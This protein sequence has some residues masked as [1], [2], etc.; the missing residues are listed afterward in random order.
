MSYANLNLEKR[1]KSKS[2]RNWL[3]LSLMSVLLASSVLLHGQQ[4]WD[5]L[6]W[7][8]DLILNA[9][10]LSDGTNMYDPMSSAVSH[11][12]AL[13]LG[14]LK[15]SGGISLPHAERFSFANSFTME[16]LYSPVVDSTGTCNGTF[17]QFSDGAANWSVKIAAN[18]ITVEA[19]GEALSANA[20]TEFTVSPE[21]VKWVHVAL[22]WERTEEVVIGE[23]E[24]AIVIPGE[25][26]LCLLLNGDEVDSLT[27]DVLPDLALGQ[28]A[29]LAD[30]FEQGFLDEFR[31]WSAARD[32]T[33]IKAYRFRHIMPGAA[34]LVAN[35]RFD[36][37]GVSIEDFAK[38]PNFNRAAK[39]HEKILDP[40][41]PDA[42]RTDLETELTA[43]F[44]YRLMAADSNVKCANMYTTT[45]DTYPQTVSV[46]AANVTIF[47]RGHALWVT[48]QNVA[49]PEQAAYYNDG[50]DT[51]EDGVADDGFPELDSTMIFAIVR[52]PNT[53]VLSTQVKDGDFMVYDWKGNSMWIL[54]KD[55]AVAPASRNSVDNNELTLTKK[56]LANRVSNPESN[57]TTG[58]DEDSDGV[59]DDTAIAYP[60]KEAVEEDYVDT[61]GDMLPD[62]WEMAFFGDLE[63]AGFGDVYGFTDTDGD[64]LNDYYEWLA[65][66]DPTK[67]ITGLPG[68]GTL[69][70]AEFD[71][72]GDGLSNLDEQKLGSPDGST[73]GTNP[74]LVDTDDDGI[75]DYV[76][77][78]G[79]LSVPGDEPKSGPLD[80]LGPSVWRA[81]RAGGTAND[82]LVIPEFDRV[83]GH[84]DADAPALTKSWTIEAWF[85]LAKVQD[86]GDVSRT[87]S[88][89]RRVALDS[90]G[91]E[92]YYFDMGLIDGKPYVRTTM[93]GSWEYEEGLTTNI[94][95]VI[96][97]DGIK[98]LDNI[99]LHYAA[100]WN[101][102]TKA[103]NLYINGTFAGSLYSQGAPIVDGGASNP[104]FVTEILG[105]RD[106]S[107][108]TGYIDEVRVWCDTPDGRKGTRLPKQIREWMSKALPLNTGFAA[109]TDFANL[110]AALY[111]FDDGGTYA[112]D[113]SY[114]IVVEIINKWRHSLQT[115]DGEKADLSA[116]M[117]STWNAFVDSTGIDDTFGFFW[118][119]TNV[120]ERAINMS[121]SGTAEFD[122]IP[123]GWQQLYWGPTA[124]GA[125]DLDQ[126]F[127]FSATPIWNPDH[128]LYDVPRQFPNENSDF[129]D[130]LT[131]GTIWNGQ[132]HSTNRW[133]D[134]FVYITDIFIDDISAINSVDLTYLVGGFAEAANDVT[135]WNAIQVFVNAERVP[136]GN[137]HTLPGGTL[138]HYPSPH[139]SDSSTSN[140]IQGTFSIGSRF[141]N[142]RNRI[143]IWANHSN[144]NLTCTASHPYGHTYTFG[145]RI[146]IN[147]RTPDN[148]T[149]HVKWFY[150]QAPSSSNGGVPD[151]LYLAQEDV[152]HAHAVEEDGTLKRYFWFE[153]YY[154]LA[155]WAYDQDPD[156]DG[157]TNW[158]EY[159]ANTNPLNPDVDGDGMLDGEHDYD[160][161]G[162]NN[163]L[164][165]ALNTFIN[166]KD[167]DDDGVDDY[168]EFINGSDPLDSL[169]V[170]NRSNLSL[171]ADGTYVL[172]VPEV[173]DRE[174]N[175]ELRNWTLEA[176]VKP[177]SATGRPFTIVNPG[178]EDELIVID[179]DADGKRQ[180]IMART[181]GR[182]N[183]I[184]ATN[185]EMGLTE[186]GLPYAG[187]SVVKD[188]PNGDGTKI[189]ANIHATMTAT[190]GHVPWEDGVWHHLAAVFTAPN[191]VGE[192]GSIIIYVDGKQ[193][194]ARHNIADKPATT[195]RGIGGITIA[196]PLPQEG[197]VMGNP[198]AP[199]GGAFVGLIDNVAIWNVPRTARQV[200][201]T[202]LSGL[203]S[204]L[205]T[206][207]FTFNCLKVATPYVRSDATLMHAFLF[208]DG[209]KT[210][211][212]YAW[213]RD[214][215]NGFA[216]AISAPLGKFTVYELQVE[217]D[218]NGD[219]VY[220]VDDQGNFVY[221]ANNE[222]VV[223]MVPFDP[224][225]NILVKDDTRSD[226]DNLDTDGDG[227]PD[228]WEIKYFGTLAWGAEDDPD[229]DGLNNLYEYLAGKDPTKPETIT[230]KP[231]GEEDPDGDGLTNLMEQFWGTHPKKR[232]SDDDGIN[233]YD[234]IHGFFDVTAFMT[235]PNYSMAHIDLNVLDT[236]IDGGHYKITPQRSLKM[237]VL[238]EAMGNNWMGI[239]L[240]V[241]DRF[242]NVPNTATFEMWLYIDSAELEEGSSVRL[243]SAMAA[244]TITALGLGYDVKDGGAYL[245]GCFDAVDT[246]NGVNGKYGTKEIKVGGKDA[247][248]SKLTTD[249]WN[250]V[251][252]TWDTTLG[253]LAVIIDG[254]VELAMTKNHRPYIKSNTTIEVYLGGDGMDNAKSLKSGL[255][256]EVRV[257]RSTKTAGELRAANGA[258]IMNIFHPD[259]LAYYRFDD[260]GLNI[261]DFTVPYPARNADTY[262]LK[263]KDYK[264]TD[265][266]SESNIGVDADGK[267]VA[268]DWYEIDEADGTSDWVVCTG[269]KILRGLD[270]GDGD[271]LPDWWEA[272][273]NRY[274]KSDAYSMTADGDDDNFDGINGDYNQNVAGGANT[275]GDD[276][277]SN[278]YEYYCRTSPYSRDSDGNGVLDG[279]EDFDGDGLSNREEMRY[280]SDPRLIDTDD[281]EFTD[282]EEIDANTSPSHPCSNVKLDKRASLDIAA[283]VATA[284]DEYGVELYD[285]PR[286]SMGNDEWTVET[287]FQMGTDM[288]GDIFVFES[289][290]SDCYGLSI[291]EG[292]PV[293]KIYKQNVAEPTVKVGGKA[294]PDAVQ[295]PQL[296]QGKWY[297]LALV[298]TPTKHSF[299]LYLDGI[300]MIAVQTQ[301]EADI[302]A[303]KAYLAKN[304][305][306]GFID[307]F[308]V[309]K[310]ARSKK[311]LNRW[312]YDI[313]P[314]HNTIDK[315]FSNANQLASQL[316]PSPYSCS[317]VPAWNVANVYEYADLLVTYYRFDDGGIRAEDF[318]KMGREYSIDILGAFTSDEYAPVIGI[319]D[320][321]SDQIP[322]WWVELHGLDNW[323]KMS[324]FRSSY[325]RNSVIASAGDYLQVVANNT[326]MPTMGNYNTTYNGWETTGWNVGSL[327]RIYTQN[328]TAYDGP[329][330]CAQAGHI[331]RDFTIFGSLGNAAYRTANYDYESSKSIVTYPSGMYVQLWKY[332]VLDRKPMEAPFTLNLWNGTVLSMQVNGRAVAIT[333]AGVVDIAEYLEKGRNQIFL[334][335]QDTGGATSTLSATPPGYYIVS[336]SSATTI[337]RWAVQTVSVPRA[338]MKA[339]FA[340][341][342][343]GKEVIVNGDEYK[344]DPRAVWHGR[345]GTLASYLNQPD[346]AAK[347][348]GYQGYGLD[349]D[350]DGDGLSNLVEYLVNTNP[351]D[352]DSNNNGISDADEDF[353]GDGVKN[354]DEDLIGT[355]PTMVDTDDDGRMDNEEVSLG[356]DPADGNSPGTNGAVRFMGNAGEYLLFPN[357][358]RFA[359]STYTLEFWIRP[360][361]VGAEQTILERAVGQ[362][363]T[364]ASAKKLVNY[365]V[366]LDVEGKVAMYYTDNSGDEFALAS[367][368]PLPASE[369]THVAISFDG[370]KR[371]I[372]LYID[373]VLNR[374]SH[375]RVSQLIE[376]PGFTSVKA[377]EGFN[378][379]LDD[380][381]FWNVVRTGDEIYAGR[382][383]ALT[384]YEE[385]L[386]AY[387]RFDDF[388][389]KGGVILG[390]TAQ[391]SASAYYGDWK[392]GWRNAARF[393]RTSAGTYPSFNDDDSEDPPIIADDTLDTDGDGMP[394]EWEKL[395]GL[396]P[397]DPTDAWNDDDGD[398]LVN[399]YEYLSNTN[400]TL[401]MTNSI[402]MDGDLDY[403]MDGL[404]NLAEQFAGSL[405]ND[406][407]TDDD[408]YSDGF[409]AGTDPFYVEG[410]PVHGLYDY[411]VSPVSS[412]SQPEQ[413]PNHASLEDNDP[414]TS[415]PEKA[416]RLKK[417]AKVFRM[418]GTNRVKVKDNALQSGNVLTIQFWFRVNKTNT[419][420]NDIDKT[421]SGV[422]R[423][424]PVG[425]FEPVTFMRRTN[426]G[427]NQV[428]N[429]KFT[430]DGEAIRFFISRKDGGTFLVPAVYAPKFG[431]QTGEES[432]YLITAVID[433][434]PEGESQSYRIIGMKCTLDKLTGD[435][436][437]DTNN[438]QTASSNRSAILSKGTNAYE[439]GEFII[440]NLEGENWPERLI[441]DVDTVSFWS[442]AKEASAITTMITSKFDMSSEFGRNLVSQFIFDDGGKT[443]EDIKQP[444]DWWNDWQHAGV[445]S[446]T[447]QPG[448]DK[449]QPDTI[450]PETI[451][452]EPGLTVGRG[453]IFDSS[454]FLFNN[455]TDGDGLPDDWEIYFFGTLD[456][457]PD[458]DFDGD[459]LTNKQEYELSA[460]FR[461]PSLGNDP[462][463]DVPYAW[464]DPTSKDSDGDGLPDGWENTYRGACNPLNYGDSEIDFDG[465]GLKN[466][467][468]YFY[469]TNPENEDTDGD[470]LPDGWEVTYTRYESI[471]DRIVSTTEPTLDP[472]DPTGDY[473]RDGDPDNDGRTNEEEF[474]A[475]SNPLQ[476]DVATA[477]TDND[478]LLNGDEQRP[479]INT[480]PYL[481]DTDDDE[482]DDFLELNSGTKGFDS[483][484]KPSRAGAP[485]F[486]YKGNLVGQIDAQ[487]GTMTVPNADDPNRVGFSTWTVEARF[488]VMEIDCGDTTT[489]KWTDEDYD[490]YLVRRSF[491][492]TMYQADEMAE[493]AQAWN[494]A[495]GYRVKASDA[496]QVTK[497]LYPFISFKSKSGKERFI[498]SDVGVDI[499]INTTDI[500]VPGT[501]ALY[502]RGLTKWHFLT[503]V[504]DSIN[505]K[506][507]MYLDGEEHETKTY[508]NIVKVEDQ[509]PIDATK[510]GSGFN[511]YLKLGENFGNSTKMTEEQRKADPSYLLI[512]EVRV[513]GVKP[514][515]VA[516]HSSALGYMT[517]FFRNSTEIADGHKRPITPTWGIYDTCLDDRFN[518]TYDGGGLVGTNTH[519]FC[520]DEHVSDSEWTTKPGTQGIW[521]VVS[522]HDQNANGHWD[523]GEDVWRDRTVAEAINEDALLEDFDITLYEVE[524]E[525]Q[526]MVNV[527]NP[528]IDLR[529]SYGSDGWV[530]GE[531][532][533]RTTQT[534][535]ANGTV[536]TTNVNVTAEQSAI[537]RTMEVFYV[538]K[539][540]NG[541]LDR[542]DNFWLEF[543]TDDVDNWY[544]PAV[545]GWA[546]RQG[547]ALYLRF[548]DGGGSIE[549]YARRSD[550]RSS[551]AWKH[552]IRPTGVFGVFPPNAYTAIGGKEYGFYAYVTEPLSDTDDFRWVTNA[553]VAPKSPGVVIETL[554]N[555]ED[556]DQDGSP[557]VAY[558][559]AI[560]N[561]VDDYDVLTAV[562]K[563]P[564]SDPEGGEITYRYFW[565][566]ENGY[567]KDQL[568]YEDGKLKTS[569]TDDEELPDGLLITSG[570]ELDLY[571][572]RSLIK[573]GDVV[574]LA[575]LAT[576]ETGM[577]SEIVLIDV[578]IEAR[579]NK[580][581]APV[582]FDRYNS[583]T[584]SP[585]SPITVTLKVNDTR[586]GTV[587][588][589]WYRNLG[590]MSWESKP[591]AAGKAG[592]PVNFTVNG[593]NVILGDVWGYKAYF[594]PAGTETKSRTTPPETRDDNDWE[595][596]QVGVGYDE[597]VATQKNR[598]PTMPTSVIIT[599][600]EVDINSMLIATASGSTDPDP[601]DRF[602]YMYQWYQNGQIVLGE[603]FPYFP[604]ILE[605]TTI[606]DLEGETTNL[607]VTRLDEGDVINV[608]VWAVD[609]HG[610]ASNVLISDPVIISE[611]FAEVN[612]AQTAG[613]VQAYEPNGTPETAT[614]LL[615][616]ENWVNVSDPNV[617][618]HYFFDRSDVDWFWFVV[619]QTLS[620]NPSIV[621]IETNNGDIMFYP[622]HLYADDQALN[623]TY[624]ELYSANNL[625]RAIAVNEDTRLAD[626]KGT[627][628]A[629]LEV[630][631]E[632]G[633]YYVKVSRS[634]IQ[635]NVQY[636]YYMH[637]G[638]EEKGGAQGPLWMEDAT[639]LLLPAAPTAS[640]N[641]ECIVDP[642]AAIASTG[643]Y[644]QYY[645]VWY[646]NGE[647]VPFG[648]PAQVS[649]WSTARYTISN[650]KNYSSS[651]P[652]IVESQY[653]QAGEIWWCVVYARDENG[654]T[655]GIMSNS[656]TI[657]GAQW[658]MKMQVTKTYRDA[659]LGAV[660]GD[661]Q[662]ITIG[663]D[664]DATFGFDP[665][666]DSAAATRYL[667][668][669]TTPDDTPL[670]LGMTYSIGM[671]NTYT[672]LNRDFRPYG[673]SSTWYIKVEMGL[674]E[675]NSSVDSFTLS[676][677]NVVA[678][679]DS[680]GGLQMTRMIELTDKT[681]E[682]M[683][684]TTIN[685][686][687]QRSITLTADELSACQQDEYGQYFVVYR[688]TL[689]AADEAQSITLKP[690]WNMISFAVTPLNN[691]VADVFA[692]GNI[693]L[694]R[695]DV[696]RYEDG[697]YLASASVLA[698]NGYWVYASVKS[699]TVVTVFGNRPQDVW[700]MREGWNLT[701]P[702]YNVEDFKTQ[703]GDYTIF[704]DPTLI[705]Q[706]TSDSKGNINYIDI[707]TNAGKYPMEVGKAYWIYSAKGVA[708][709]VYPTDK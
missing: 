347:E 513:W 401:M 586:A 137:S 280:G 550:W 88:L 598:P 377:G 664:D 119:D 136:Y 397:E 427:V 582:T 134:A 232:D 661:D 64:G 689:G 544:K 129:I 581:P 151:I 66:T 139:Y 120:G 489:E 469:G 676:W 331:A 145:A 325:G 492:A 327:T 59:A 215:Y 45:D 553:F 634:G 535:A 358:G 47:R 454:F 289:D 530:A 161:D 55:P 36:D 580:I 152:A 365:G 75:S 398:G 407:D 442:E 319:D 84:D 230:G 100:T 659:A 642:K 175:E 426:A 200:A 359:L 684:E 468:E 62:D 182:Y 527:Y 51:D 259:M 13:V 391:D 462:D 693:R 281:D 405:P 556:I 328:P 288:D 585:G 130:P 559:P 485:N 370:A 418:D 80:P 498:R 211:E 447:L 416:E 61:D 164:E 188:N 195:M 645:Y 488:R 699:T 637:L 229:G 334:Y 168:T 248:N 610:N 346:M 386:V 42:E 28:T 404:T 123:D 688:I 106:G 251:A 600:K 105:Q 199:I 483:L 227:L 257:W 636:P 243:M 18:V 14:Q 512:D 265:R 694:V 320:E 534:V 460:I 213:K 572:Y 303:G 49:I 170:Y 709:P 12:R 561:S 652:H 154:A 367:K 354:I 341:N 24:E 452:Y 235:H 360:E 180:V 128:N 22:V 5:P 268:I 26:K 103:L 225:Y 671:N 402:D 176:W 444:D 654:F 458:D 34:N 228:N 383:N 574:T 706:A 160:L 345:T 1:M 415:L 117:L 638:I 422:W 472:L 44:E 423:T 318:A 33:V 521:A 520:V 451:Q 573:N 121:G 91:N 92:S 517:T 290:I 115:V 516:I 475:G 197:E 566:Y 17:F 371:N 552:A 306:D 126:D 376:G 424:G 270:D 210:I 484:S 529:L 348:V 408:G 428:D 392:T 536:T 361:L 245:Y 439:K 631:L 135:G 11:A 597:E 425:K 640:Q 635:Y 169:D 381:R 194:Y 246:I 621:K 32:F 394:D 505:H 456:M 478:G 292:Y 15:S 283:Y 490:V 148:Y 184:D 350:P 545:A 217:T 247:L 493:D 21:S 198:D 499:E 3:I 562:I 607:P 190:A 430:F 58:Q 609:L 355:D 301:A 157:L 384:G 7:D 433:A 141:K 323:R 94:G 668:G 108:L 81:L 277:L 629:R 616:K 474:L 628:F 362:I 495:I 409:E 390:E 480:D 606:T 234:E 674:R 410:V 632:P 35:Y 183:G 658:Q 4:K 351:F 352:K 146:R 252:V 515:K 464:M 537:G 532:Y 269:A 576:S 260:A 147:G 99:W 308:R 209:G 273:Y 584:A 310:E 449:S 224:D 95:E 399:L 162:L 133:Q 437:Y 510:V 297:H 222:K 240:P 302:G 692:D 143:T 258:T 203:S 37:G 387:Y 364:G 708:L 220:M 326:D 149:G 633:M 261:E 479:G 368:E 465:D 431:F 547:L 681:W 31:F 525:D 509:C 543:N 385:N 333:G 406:P 701:G 255:V 518:T 690:G 453:M 79:D 174:V 266:K 253:R 39:I 132:R 655:E 218:E 163:M 657:S 142:G 639:A 670:P 662:A 263:A 192:G 436:S 595:F 375:G 89:I 111:R 564:A 533:T 695:G 683:S 311:E 620:D 205:S 502:R 450:K 256:D 144:Y 660:T 125:Y 466:R 287:W 429:Y 181:V 284:G 707:I 336:T 122:P 109:T 307:E 216:H 65:G 313:I 698:G 97:N 382:E 697:Q 237:S 69:T 73:L 316:V 604:A 555:A 651:K 68:Q 457:G 503:G 249:A 643:G 127:F 380:L 685:M 608:K 344:F 599:P 76:E 446:H 463:Y 201:Q 206:G 305:S 593:M 214:W 158:V 617:Q 186:E 419:L 275:G 27:T 374:Q 271:G 296:E 212:N 286:F 589:R 20:L 630:E 56:A 644:A 369:W 242:Q 298:W 623:D 23:G 420:G 207:T 6:D 29:L 501:E 193:A 403:D 622:T 445:L 649:A 696:W 702:I 110:P 541:L 238:N 57:F 70:D 156:G 514:N 54:S 665:S 666:F 177:T 471:I 413:G 612:E 557:D 388:Y 691:N 272:F 285:A 366:R 467:E 131:G 519:N 571:N 53:S 52:K 459:G 508:T 342:V 611:D 262:E 349:N 412:T 202:C 486:I 647:V 114:P 274:D 378:G 592:R 101:P 461:D 179:E 494:Y 315:E 497:K 113:F 223:S 570:K 400:P 30:G 648:E 322:E 191:E 500:K 196:G 626:G 2:K 118:S 411:G 102:A 116:R 77:I 603:T 112:Q 421:P 353:D 82:V 602:A 38:L 705:K 618:E 312:L 155:P 335:L 8:D 236:E 219:V 578:E 414:T 332:I 250:H 329:T 496:N 579:D 548:D 487:H 83:L 678:P 613:T 646:R 208:D 96:A 60:M 166:V 107:Y 679:T 615:P 434:D 343:D 686:T 16:F 703:Y 396:D 71:S 373:G 153:K 172:N 591:V 173:G 554:S 50:F 605:A 549:D 625:R 677:D 74:S 87:G 339:D 85:Q 317:Q 440:G 19:F 282:K 565:L 588:I 663:L 481:T 531:A 601:G 687:Q 551:P 441:I 473:G 560:G 491:T 568:F 614:R 432:L 244:S 189:V 165:Q 650:A 558:I 393:I 542:E 522:Y 226:V 583:E 682:P 395:Y 672:K 150:V 78:Y 563:V 567:T 171:R 546:E 267:Q 233:D 596:I 231:D 86:G 372:T 482:F 470:G 675:G 295:I 338:T 67:P 587:H 438:T 324:N 619:P 72:D 340:L 159:L 43:M 278:L 417:I 254:V 700:Q 627:R 357:L 641:L 476:P 140:A 279:N 48:A 507:Y 291:E 25:G 680:V 41:T 93:Q 504:Y 653:T 443:A 264:V 304:L 379:Y 524:D 526:I 309:W 314:T 276:G 669:T 538:D 241:N 523:E 539:N 294:A 363:G 569:E 667:P 63:T 124:G 575:A 40:A 435:I 187:F 9:D 98:A 577:G 477:D 656:V 540:G 138:N 300:S 356:Y 293:G 46:T 673:R 455:D 594:V 167:T 299:Q 511:T 448:E 90:E 528:G 185:Y 10:E 104:E 204:I 221:D 178:T 330:I 321:D 506:L 624:M 590:L 239:K 704:I 337:S 389:N